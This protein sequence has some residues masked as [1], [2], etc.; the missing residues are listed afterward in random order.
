MEPKHVIGL[1]GGK[2]STCLALAL[3][4]R[5][6]RDYEYIFTPT[7]DELPEL[8]AHLERVEALLGKK[9]TRIT[10]GKTLDEIIEEEG[11]LPNFR[12]RFCT[13]ILKI[14]PTIEYMAALPPG[15]VL[16]VGLRADEAEREG[17]YGDDVQSDFPFRRWGWGIKEVWAYLDQRGI[18]VP[19]RTDCGKC[20]HQRVGEWRNLWRDHPDRFKAAA[21]LEERM[22]HTFRSPG[23]DTW[24]VKL[25]DMGKEFERGRKIRGDV[26]GEHAGERCRVCSL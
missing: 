6:P 12:A 18:S 14:E 13:R 17:L 24:P 20:Y 4:E 2:D 19:A 23:R 7:G 15:S 21:G 10:C 1:S 5:E 11:M 16:Y 3:A 25:V 22:G 9:I 26:G 8:H